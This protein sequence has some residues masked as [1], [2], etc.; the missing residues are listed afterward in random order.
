MSRMDEKLRN[1]RAGR[2][3]KKDFM[4]A[5]AK[6]N[7]MGG[8]CTSMGPRRT[9][10][11]SANGFRSRQEYLQEIRTVLKQDIVDIMLVSA[12]NLEVLQNEGLFKGS[13]VQPA[14]RAN[15][16]T[17][18]WGGLRGGNYVS[19]PSRPFRTANI[20]RLRESQPNGGTDLG[21]YSVTF[22]NDIDAD[23]RSLEAYAEFR[24]EASANGFRHF[25]EVFNPNAA[26]RLDK[27][28]IPQ[29]VND[30]IVRALAGVMDADRP[31]FLK[32]PFNGPEAMEELCSYDS[33]LVVGVLGGGAG[34]TRDTFELLRQAEKFGARLALFGRKINMA[35][36]PVT[37]VS[38]MR[39]V[40]DGDLGTEEAVRFYHSELDKLGM[41]PTRSLEEDS[42]ITE[43]PLRKAA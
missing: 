19:T 11:G 10:D 24:S 43:A 32:M 38:T 15:D 42:K 7:D 25:L 41:R 12:S 16:T 27:E 33:S 23:M 14:I 6:D 13:H 34:T 37:M 3:T 17:D 35:E 26:S 40:V 2:Y 5:D 9:K 30:H 36:S 20:K 29:F 39:R 31:L 4:L 8:G 21:L 18:C 22:N 28:K 1:I